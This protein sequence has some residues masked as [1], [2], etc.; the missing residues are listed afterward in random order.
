MDG[1]TDRA[2]RRKDQIRNGR[3]SIERLA[4]IHSPPNSLDLAI[5]SSSRALSIRLRFIPLRPRPRSSSL[6]PRFPSVS[7][8]QHPLVSLRRTSL[9]Y[10]SSRALPIIHPPP[11]LFSSLLLSSSSP[12][13]LVILSIFCLLNIPL[14]PPCI[15]IPNGY[16]ELRRRCQ[17][18]IRL[19]STISRQPI[20]PENV[21]TRQHGLFSTLI[22]VCTCARM[23]SS[24][25][26]AFE[27]R[28]RRDRPAASAMVE[29][30][31]NLGRGSLPSHLPL[32]RLVAPWHD[33]PSPLLRT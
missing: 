9:I 3:W 10:L 17:H 20:Y 14:Y 16:T 21:R 13:H 11:R 18:A 24:C 30:R 31:S 19:L 25:W 22:F 5:S 15:S 12:F 27:L 28:T 23:C 2:L 6:P 26:S 32:A 33:K 29:H 8:F 4:S 7:R 1:R